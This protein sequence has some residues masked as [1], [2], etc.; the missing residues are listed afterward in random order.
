MHVEAEAVPEP[1]A[2]R[3]REVAVLD[4]AP[5]RGV[6]ID[7]PY[8]GPNRLQ[9]GLLSRE[10]D[11][12][13]LP[14]LSLQLARGERPRVVR[15]VATHVRPGIDP[16]QLTGLDDPVAGARVRPCSGRPGAD[17]RLECRLVRPF[18]VV[19]PRDVPGDVALTAA[20][21]PHPAPAP[22]PQ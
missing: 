6:R 5:R 20:D 10:H 19:E 21:P 11:V 18:L 3:T 4:D 9:P 1:V 17:D 13:R 12:V 2:E 7:P 16:H 15:D 14:H 22:L 8:P